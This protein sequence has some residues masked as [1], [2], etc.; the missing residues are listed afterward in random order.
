MCLAAHDVEDY[1]VVGGRGV[2]VAEG[3]AARPPGIVQVSDGKLQGVKLVPAEHLH[4]GSRE[5]A[6]RPAFRGS[7]MSAP[8]PETWTRR[9][10]YKDE[11]MRAREH[12]GLT[13]ASPPAPQASPHVCPDR[14][15]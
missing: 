7:R 3:T 1:H 13:A 10:L 11:A 6:D 14:R 8:R 9:G 5:G 4:T 2:P 15:G 12:G